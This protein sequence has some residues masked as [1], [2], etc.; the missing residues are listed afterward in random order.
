MTGK[1]GIKCTVLTFVF[2]VSVVQAQESL[3][4]CK[5]VLNEGLI[6]QQSSRDVYKVSKSDF[7]DFCSIQESKAANFQNRS[8]SFKAGF[9]DFSSSLDIGHAAGEM[10]SFTEEAFDNVC[11]ER[12]TNF[13]T[14]LSKSTQAST[15]TYL[16]QQFTTCVSILTRAGTPFL[17][18][19]IQASGTRSVFTANFEYFRGTAGDLNVTLT[20]INGDPIRCYKDNVNFSEHVLQEGQ[21]WLLSGKDTLTCRKPDEQATV[22]GSF[23]FA[24]EGGGI[25]YSVPYEFADSSARAEIHRS[26]MVLNSARFSSLDAAV[27]S[28]DDRLATLQEDLRET[29]PAGTIAFFLRECPGR[30]SRYV[31]LDNRVPIGT[32]VPEELGSQ[33]GAN[34]V[35][36]PRRALP[37][38]A[39]RLPSKG[40]GGNHPNNAGQPNQGDNGVQA[41]SGGANYDHHGRTTEYMGEGAALELPMPPGVQLAA[42]IKT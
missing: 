28:L 11:R 34:T 30:W 2:L 8:S 21:S 12:S 36:I 1:H 37:R 22:A 17:T 39:L 32:S 35:T 19:H 15:G 41:T 3:N 27:S 29:I 24:A 23:T 20:A 5:S 33:V 38:V 4:H 14:F 18:G 10:S 16:A 9:S 31:G 25:T 26:L 7:E 40:H 6:D 13:A 42:C